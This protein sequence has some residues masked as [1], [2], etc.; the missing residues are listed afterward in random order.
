MM[1][2]VYRREPQAVTCCPSDRHVARSQFPKQK[3]PFSGEGEAEAERLRE[4][5]GFPLPSSPFPHS[6]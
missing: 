1:S 6:L 2:V 3:A 4:A 5:G